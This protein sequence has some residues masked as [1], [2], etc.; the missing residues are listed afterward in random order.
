M[1]FITKESGLCLS[2][3]GAC[4]GAF[5][6]E[7]DVN[8]Y[9]KS[10]KHITFVNVCN[11]PVE[12]TGLFNPDPDRFTLMNTDLSGL[13]V[14]NSDNPLT[15]LPQ[16]IQPYETYRINT[17]FHPKGEDFAAANFGTLANP[18]G[19]QFG[20]KI[21]VSPGDISFPNCENF[22]T[23]SGEFLC[24]ECKVDLQTGLGE[25]F[26]TLD[27]ADMPAPEPPPLASFAEKVYRIESAGAGNTTSSTRLLQQIALH[28]SGNRSSTIDD[29]I[30]WAAVAQHILNA[31]VGYTNGTTVDG[32]A[33]NFNSLVINAASSIQPKIDGS[34]NN[35]VG[36][37][38]GN[39]GVSKTANQNLF[40]PGTN[41]VGAKYNTMAWE[42][43][44]LSWN[45]TDGGKTLFIS[46][47]IEAARN[48]LYASFLQDDGEGIAN[49]S[50]TQNP[51][52]LDN[53][54]NLGVSTTNGHGPFGNLEIN[55]QLSG[56]ITINYG[57]DASLNITSERGNFVGS[58]GFRD[59][60]D[61]L[62]NRTNAPSFGN[63]RNCVALGNTGLR[64]TYGTTNTMFWNNI[65]NAASSPY[66]T[67]DIVPWN[68][69]GYDVFL[70]NTL[71]FNNGAA[72]AAPANWTFGVYSDNMIGSA[73]QISLRLNYAG[74][75]L[76]IHKI[77]FIRN[78]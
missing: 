9:V 36:L 78:N 7:C 44:P 23:I 25:Y 14:Y 5:E 43:T 6:Q 50:L 30:H 60:D 53:L 57:G 18:T 75:S 64:W 4:E 66:Y 69:N 49:I 65:G 34:P 42:G 38:E 51:F 29:R 52:E 21:I 27:F 73:G 61:N 28:G 16:T 48:I 37:I 3:T 70:N 68:I 33:E 12:V 2:E 45:A 26:Q 13:S 11:Q 71:I 47:G 17:F 63:P 46:G 19:S 10:G 39:I 77:N 15:N 58:M 74:P 32:I 55:A 54:V 20:S 1:A 40:N 31:G 22:F 35:N 72:Q 24:R 76:D 8:F 41:W 67:T 59:G 56:A 62:Y